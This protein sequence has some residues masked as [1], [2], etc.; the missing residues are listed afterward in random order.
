LN[1]PLAV[2]PSGRT[3]IIAYRLPAA[4][5]TIDTAT[6]QT[7]DLRSACGDADDLFLMGNRVVLVCG[8]GHVDVY[9]ADGTRF[10]MST[11]SGARTGLYV[12]ELGTLFVAAPAR[13]SSAAI[14][15]LRVQEQTR[16]P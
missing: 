3:I 4:L 10:R 6:G 9:Q 15:A 7:R 2:D 1:F 5:A 13:G 12:P 11:A 14:L 16:N 8:A